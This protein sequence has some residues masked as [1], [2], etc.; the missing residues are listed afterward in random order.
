MLAFLVSARLFG[1]SDSCFFS[2]GSG[3]L[4]LA[5]A[6]LLEPP[7]E[8]DEYCCKLGVG[9]LARAVEVA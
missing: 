4:S 8:K 5:G 7:E 2:L 6:G 9:I 3:L 1:F